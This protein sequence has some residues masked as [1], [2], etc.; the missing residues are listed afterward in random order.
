MNNINHIIIKCKDEPYCT[1][2]HEI[3]NEYYC[4]YC[5]LKIVIIQ[6]VINI[7]ILILLLK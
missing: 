3:H 7:Q 1:D 5:V 2:D 6:L 4:F